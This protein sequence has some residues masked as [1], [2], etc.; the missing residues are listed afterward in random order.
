MASGQSVFTR[1]R[2][3]VSKL[4]A[5]GRKGVIPPAARV[6][7][8][9]V[10]HMTH[11]GRYEGLVDVNVLEQDAENQGTR[12]AKVPTWY[13]QSS[14]GSPRRDDDTVHRL[15]AQMGIAQRCIQVILDEIFNAETQVV[16]VDPTDESPYTL[17]KLEE[18]KE[19]MKACNANEAS[20]LNEWRKA[21]TDFYEV[22]DGVMVKGFA[23]E[24]YDKANDYSYVSSS[25]P[26]G[27]GLFKELQAY[28]A[29]Q[30]FVFK[31]AFGQI[32]GHFQF[33]FV[34][35]PPAFFSRRELII[36]QDQPTTY[37][38]YGRSR[39][40]QIKDMLEMVA[41]W[42]LQMK[43]YYQKGAVFQ[44]FIKTMGLG[45]EEQKRMEKFV[46]EKFKQMQHKFGF[47]H[48]GKDTDIDFVPLML[49]VKDLA[50]LEGMDF[51]QRFVMSI[52]GVMPNE[53]GITDSVNK[54][55]SEQQGQVWRRRTVKTVKKLLTEVTNMEIIKEFDPTGKIEWRFTEEVDEQTRQV[56]QRVVS[57][58]IDRSQITI[59]EWRIEEG[60]K[61]FGE[62]WSQIPFPIYQI[63]MEAK[64]AEQQHQRDRTGEEDKDEDDK[65][66]NPQVMTRPPSSKGGD[67]IQNPDPTLSEVDLGPASKEVMAY[68]AEQGWGALPTPVMSDALKQQAAV[69]KQTDPENDD[70]EEWEGLT[71]EEME[72]RLNQLLDPIE[73]KLKTLLIAILMAWQEKLNAI[74]L[75]EDL[76][77][78]EIEGIINR[79]INPQEMADEIRTALFESY[80]TGLKMNDEMEVGLIPTFSLPD[81]RLRQYFREYPLLISEKISKRIEGNL[82]YTLAEAVARGES[83]RQM[84]SRIQEVMDN[85]RYEAERIARTEVTNGATWGRINQLRAMGETHWVYYA[86]LDERT[87]PECLAEHGKV[88]SLDDLEKKPPLHPNCRCTILSVHSMD[89]VPTWATPKSMA[90]RDPWYP[91]KRQAR[92]ELTSNKSIKFILKQLYTEETQS[93]REIAGRY[94]VTH[95]TVCNW[96]HQFEIPIREPV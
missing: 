59:D 77:I 79:V 89:D 90:E 9:D 95:Q 7:L 29:T 61:P 36:L 30:F 87:C 13:M 41:A 86:T 35:T 53:L 25:A 93:T 72:Q 23:P 33:N 26:A 54:A 63:Q 91:S 76:R 40:G 24:A 20:Y 96:L 46:E 56:Q 39:I 57:E 58:Q 2:H 80:D 49:S 45:D 22:G 34:H 83:I 69:M 12:K 55:T 94:G 51:V 73:R 10:H 85:T 66:N 18:V 4:I 82:R 47:F 32:L 19:W 75:T 81:H 48:G 67:L 44:G 15:L 14:Y 31:T 42:M 38:F 88:F 78:D 70:D 64:Q 62:E 1:L 52:F 16:A 68:L 50:F 60:K 27:V 43:R 5:P 8:V 17:G 37:K 84:R 92:V 6:K 65:Q 28:D 21:L 74:H 71:D 11:M 3:G